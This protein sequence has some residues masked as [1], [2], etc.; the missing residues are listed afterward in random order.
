MSKQL[1][2]EQWK[3]IESRVNEAEAAMRRRRK[4]SDE[5]S[6]E[7]GMT[8][9]ERESKGN[10]AALASAKRKRVAKKAFKREE[11]FEKAAQFVPN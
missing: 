5:L 8:K 3:K 1:S 9:G 7:T 2:H 10:E 11:D 6:G 4:A